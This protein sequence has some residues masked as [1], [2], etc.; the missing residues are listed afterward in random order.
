MMQTAGRMRERL[1]RRRRAEG[2]IELTG[3]IT[4]DVMMAM[5]LEELSPSEKLR[6]QEHV[7]HCPVCQRQYKVYREMF[8]GLDKMVSEA[9]GA[10]LLRQAVQSKIRQKLIN[11]DLMPQTR[12]D[13]VFRSLAD[14][15]RMGCLAP[16][17]YAQ[18]LPWA[19]GHGYVLQPR[20][21]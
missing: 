7:D 1:R 3:H 2:H 4:E 12:D 6:L 20:S 8:S 11:Y 13:H 19:T 9:G 14:F 10:A 15:D 17:A 16:S 21:P 5:Y 18:L